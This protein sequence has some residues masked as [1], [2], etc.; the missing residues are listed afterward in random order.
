MNFVAIDIETANP[1]QSSVCAI[2]LVV[3]EGGKI[4][5]E[6]HTLVD[7]EDEFSR[8]HTRLHGISADYVKG[9]PTVPEILNDLGST[10]GAGTMVHHGPFDRIGFRRAFAKHGHPPWPCRWL[11]NLMVARRTWFEHAGA[12]GYGLKFLSRHYGIPLVDHHDPVHDARAAGLLFLRAS[13]EAGRSVD[14]WLV[15]VREPIGRPRS[16]VTTSA[17]VLAEVLANEVI[18]FTGKLSVERDVAKEEARAAGFDVADNVTKKTTI[19]VVGDQDLRRLAGKAVSGSQLKAE[20]LVD[21]GQS[22]RIVT[23][24]DF[25]DLI[26]V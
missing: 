18:V 8:H 21:Q 17:Q 20:K 6:R 9:K 5:E 10:F 11:D 23:E 3:F 2:G 25:R 12:G 24:S 1:D 19:L 13:E 14:D 4:V 22:I 26:A 16:G 15:R 7:P